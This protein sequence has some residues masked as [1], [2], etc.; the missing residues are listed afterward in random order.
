[1]FTRRVKRLFIQGWILLALL[2]G[3]ACFPVQREE[4][5]LTPILVT[6]APPTVVAVTP[7]E[8]APTATATTP[9]TPTKPVETSTVEPVTAT[10]PA[11]ATTVATSVGTVPAGA[12]YVM[13]LVDLNLRSGPGLGYS[14]VGWMTHGQIARVTGASSD[15][16]WWQLDCP[17][18][19]T[20]QCWVTAG[21]AYTKPQP[22]AARIQFPAGATSQTVSST[23]FGADQINY[24]FAAGAGQTIT[25]DVTPSDRMLLHVQGLRDGKTYKH[26]LSGGSSWQGVSPQAQDYLLALNAIGDS[27]SYTI[28]ISVTNGAPPVTSE[29][30]GG[31][32]PGG[33]LYP[34]VDAASG[35]LLGGMQNGVWIDG[36]TYANYLQD[37][38][39]DY[40]VFTVAGRQGNVRGLPPTIVGPVCGQAIVSFQPYAQRT[41][42]ALITRWDPAPRL[43]QS[44]AVDTPE[45]EELVASI[46]Q[47]QGLANP[48]IKIDSI[49]R[50]DLDGDA[51]DEV[52]ITAS[53][54]GG[55]DRTPAVA[56][57]DYA[58]LVLRKV[59]ND[60]VTVVPLGLDVYPEA[61]DLAYPIRYGV[62][63]L[64][65][66]SGDGYLEIVVEEQR[67]EG[68]RVTAYEITSAGLQ[69]VLQAGCME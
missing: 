68:R 67:Y 47:E 56:A 12:S 18:S 53:R 32:V 14:V 36:L 37:T 66:L 21:S 59:T 49:L 57:G 42:V 3:V 27:V 11:P 8:T 34:V 65:D 44:L 64:L 48:E 15:G 28:R 2:V 4:P 55:E 51:V 54:L 50:I 45:Y 52:L 30:G 9:A 20:T 62:L 7:S 6:T 63:G 41:G 1:M 38:E 5:A 22:D 10:A 29:P 58:L 69:Q 23:M 16:G 61:N 35:Y 46:L 25:I 39:R 13:A 43:A 40:D 17:S 60:V 31:D 24:V 19:T 33:P 26:L